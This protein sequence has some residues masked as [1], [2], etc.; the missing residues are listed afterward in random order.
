MT[1]PAVGWHAQAQR[2]RV[3]RWRRFMETASGK[4]RIRLPP[5]EPARQRRAR[6]WRILTAGGGLLLAST[7]FM[8]AV[9]G[10]NVPII[11]AREIYSGLSD[12]SFGRLT[13]VEFL[14]FCFQC[15]L[16]FVCAY[17]FGLCVAG[18]GI[19]NLASWRRHARPYAGAGILVLV[20][21]VLL[22]SVVSHTD[23]VLS[24]T[25]LARRILARISSAL[26]VQVNPRGSLLCSAT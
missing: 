3:E 1:T 23:A 20:G 17:L 19:S 22:A 10:C 24:S 12:P 15:Y 4:Q 26:A 6:P 8:P 2:G 16:L 7:F 21:L 5:D 14:D 18:R 11:P 25:F 9:P 13:F